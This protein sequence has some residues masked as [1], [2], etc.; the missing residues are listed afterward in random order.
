MRQ[1][2]TMTDLNMPGG[3]VSHVGRCLRSKK[4][5]TLLEVLVA[6]AI[7]GIAVTITFQLFS[8]NL[9]A[10]TISEDY[11]QAATKAYA[12]MREVVDDDDL[13][14]K[15]WRETTTDGYDMEVGVSETLQDRT[16]DLPVQLLEVT[17]TIH[18]KQ[19]AKEKKMTIRTMKMIERKV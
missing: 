19:G 18:W 2:A 15:S 4:G 8:A 11:V 9:R 16:R 1:I 10:L 12:R 6:L 17:L 7:L 13:A 3:K 5:F 14:V